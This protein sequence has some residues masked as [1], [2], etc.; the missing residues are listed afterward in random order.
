M[1]HLTDRAD[2]HSYFASMNPLASKIMDT[3][4]KVKEENKFAWDEMETEVKEDIFD[5]VLIPG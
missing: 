4:I 2:V 5:D 3:L 1:S